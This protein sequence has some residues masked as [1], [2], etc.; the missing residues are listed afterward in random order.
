MLI[1]ADD[2]SHHFHQTAPPRVKHARSMTVRLAQVS[3]HGTDVAGFVGRL[4]VGADV[5]AIRV[6]D[7]REQDFV[8]CN[9]VGVRRDRVV[10]CGFEF[11]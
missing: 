10:W 6:L 8:E 2:S 5:G 1:E 7:V 11:R 4:P 9:R 3:A